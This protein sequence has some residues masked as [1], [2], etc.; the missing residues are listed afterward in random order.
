MKVCLDER[1]ENVELSVERAYT[2]VLREARGGRCRTSNLLYT[3]VD[4]VLET[5]TGQLRDRLRLRG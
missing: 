4:W 5:E 2:V 1:P 3:N